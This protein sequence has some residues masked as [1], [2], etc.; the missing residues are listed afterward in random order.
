MEIIVAA[1]N[2]KNIK[3]VFKD[4][5]Y[6]YALC[7]PDGGVFYIGKGKGSRVNHHFQDNSLGRSNSSKNL[8]IRKYGDL[9]KREILCYFTNEDSAYDYEEWLIAYYG[10]ES[11]GGVLR[12]YAKT[13][14]EYSECFKEVASEQSRKKSTK[15]VEDLVVMVYKMYFTDCENR[16]YI[17]ECTGVSF[18]TI[19]TW[20]VGSK[21]RVLFRKYVLGGLIKK[22]REVT[23]EF[24]LDKRY[25]VTEL[26]SDR[27]DWVNGK[28]TADIAMKYGVTTP[29]L[30]KLFYGGSC[31][32]LFH[33]YTQL[34]ERC[35]NRKNKSK[36]LEDRIY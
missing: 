30:L 29:K 28:P 36:W 3:P 22:N 17:S 7:K 21:H 24:K 15:D 18:A 32:G 31:K 23:Q 4:K 34:P 12:Q 16:Y 9:I 19:Y 14:Y 1:N 6:V 2:P 33:D 26:R 11:E 25:T 13:R 27:E 8:T 5:F 35:L 10:I 20:V